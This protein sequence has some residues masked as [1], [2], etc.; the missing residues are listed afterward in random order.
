[1][2]RS[3][4]AKRR[5]NASRKK[6]AT[7]ARERKIAAPV[8][9]ENEP[10]RTPHSR[11]FDLEV[12]PDGQPPSSLPKSHDSHSVADPNLPTIPEKSSLPP[13][14]E[15]VDP[16]PLVVARLSDPHR[17]FRTY[18]PSKEEIERLKGIREQLAKKDIEEKAR[19][20]QRFPG[21]WNFLE[22]SEGRRLF[23]IRTKHGTTYQWSRKG[24]PVL[25]N[26]DA[27]Q[28]RAIDKFIWEGAETGPCCRLPGRYPYKRT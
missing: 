1:M 23:T 17:R 20:C 15:T 6:R 19:W 16:T 28:Q 18:N 25:S 26:L 4:E 11:T 27:N 21:L 9:D 3:S 14:P 24:S 22:F 12:S 5:R 8:T 10:S 7:R 13:L 2:S